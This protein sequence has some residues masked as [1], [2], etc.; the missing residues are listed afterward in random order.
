MTDIIINQASKQSQ[1]ESH[2]LQTTLCPRLL[3]IFPLAITTIM[4]RNLVSSFAEHV[5]EEFQGNVN[6]GLIAEER[7]CVELILEN[8]QLQIHELER[9]T[10]VGNE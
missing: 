6:Q 4:D 7:V 2:S 1:I 3:S 9:C 10:E 8:N 5:N